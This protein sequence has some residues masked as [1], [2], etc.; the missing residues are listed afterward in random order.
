MRVL[1]SA[2][3]LSMALS[4]PA[5]ADDATAPPAEP[6]KAKSKDTADGVVCKR[7]MKTG[8]MI[9][10]KVC[11]TPQQRAEQQKAVRDAQERMQGNSAGVI[12]R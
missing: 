3:V 12:P 6:A 10:V 8:S 4:A 5:L 11:T 7:Q 2:F 9:A 1:V